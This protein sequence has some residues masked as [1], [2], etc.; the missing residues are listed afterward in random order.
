MRD[1]TAFHT[2]GQS[3]LLVSQGLDVS[4]NAQLAFNQPFAGEPGRAQRRNVWAGQERGVHKARSE[5]AQA[6]NLTRLFALEIVEQDRCPARRTEIVE[7][8]TGVTTTHNALDI[9]AN[10]RFQTLTVWDHI[11]DPQVKGVMK[12]TALGTRAD[13]GWKHLHNR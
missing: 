4:G 10:A 8:T 12:A 11:I 6:E 7:Y 1:R 9:L 5:T 3:G 2:R 13:S